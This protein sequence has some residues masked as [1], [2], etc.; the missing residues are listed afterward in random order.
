MLRLKALF[1]VFILVL[2]V[3]QPVLSQS[4]LSTDIFLAD[5]KFENG[6]PIFSNVENITNRDGYDNEPFF[7]ID[8]KLI[9]YTSI[10]E[11]KQADTY[12]YDM[13]NKTI[14]CVNLTPDVSEYFPREYRGSTGYAVL[15]EESDGTR[16]VVGMR[17]DDSKTVG[18]NK[19]DITNVGSFIYVKGDI[20]AFYILPNTET[21]KQSILQI[22][23]Y[24]VQ[25]LDTIAENVGNCLYTSK[26]S[27]MGE[28][29]FI[30]KMSENNWLIK[31]CIFKSHP[32][33]MRI[34][35]YSYEP[36]TV[37][38]TLPG[39]EYFCALTGGVLIAGSGS[40]L[41]A[42]NP[43]TDTEWREIADLSADGI[44]EI[45]RLAVN[46]PDDNTIAIVSIK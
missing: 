19:P 3:I 43:Q 5:M 18:Y 17:Y 32:D 26:M 28:F 13:E 44:K 46:H 23:N 41:Y 31:K 30:H 33:P 22:L 16:H 25:E 1:S 42:F 27:G 38:P 2:L 14:S 6:E 45:T 39:K 34:M 4:P 11:D 36:E 37:V 21:D 7:S 9:L 15:R 35:S 20:H 12:S 40:K 8:G 24:R 10:R 29:Y